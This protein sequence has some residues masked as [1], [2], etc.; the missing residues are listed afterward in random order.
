[1]GP[2]TIGWRRGASRKRS[3]KRSAAL[4]GSGCRARLAIRT[5]QVDRACA[6]HRRGDA[7]RRA[8]LITRHDDI[9]SM[10]AG[11]CRCAA[12]R[13]RSCR[14]YA[15]R[16]R[17]VAVRRRRSYAPPQLCSAYSPSSLF[18]HRSNSSCAYAATGPVTPLAIPATLQGS[19]LARLDR[20]APTREIAQIA[21]ALG[22]QFS[23]RA[24]G[25][26]IVRSSP[27]RGSL[28]RVR[29]RPRASSPW[30]TFRLY[31]LTP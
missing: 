7:D 22:R 9:S 3:T 18:G 30:L 11:G 8:V 2:S 6:A 20:L 19:L 10:Q 25:T 5:Q 13:R 31:G 4:R 17:S 21:A 24:L 1:V 29:S 28:T 15:L 14:A 23:H 26:Q 27:A 16:Q 12:P